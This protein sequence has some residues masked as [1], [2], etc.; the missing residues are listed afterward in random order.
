MLY[1]LYYI[2][3]DS[4]WTRLDQIRFILYD[5]IGDA[6]DNDDDDDNDMAM[7]QGM[8][9]ACIHS[10]FTFTVPLQNILH[11]LITAFM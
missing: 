10:T 3:L 2:T 9:F 7:R 1:N 11:A 8:F 5:V 4:D 6:D